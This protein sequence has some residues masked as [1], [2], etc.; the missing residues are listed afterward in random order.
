M[1]LPAGYT[2]T[3]QIMCGNTSTLCADTATVPKWYVFSTS[4]TVAPTFVTAI[5][6]TYTVQFSERFQ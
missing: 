4:F 2:G 6:G 5:A 3:V 1:T